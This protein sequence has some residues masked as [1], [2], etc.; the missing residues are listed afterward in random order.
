MA[1]FERVGT[2]EAVPADMAKSAKY[3]VF[4]NELKYPGVHVS[5]SI[6]SFFCFR[7]DFII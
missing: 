4:E 5:S 2:S 7:V 3:V 6:A 1:G